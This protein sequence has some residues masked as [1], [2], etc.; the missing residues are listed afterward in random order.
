MLGRLVL[1]GGRSLCCHF[2]SFCLH[3]SLP[4]PS[5][6][7]SFLG[8]CL[9]TLGWQLPH[10]LFHPDCNL[11]SALQCNVHYHCHMPGGIWEGPPWRSSDCPILVLCSNCPVSTSQLICHPKEEGSQVLAVNLKKKHRYASR[12]AGTGPGSRCT[13]L[14]CCMHAWLWLQQNERAA[15]FLYKF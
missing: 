7:V 10:L 14:P 13:W 15:Q 4:P 9:E 8:L 1:E 11:H 6:E 5:S 2:L 12:K 3:F